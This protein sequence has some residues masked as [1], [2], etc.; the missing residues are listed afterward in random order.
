M[1]PH[2]INRPSIHLL[3]MFIHRRRLLHHTPLTPLAS[4]TTPTIPSPHP[5]F[6]QHFSL[7][8]ILLFE[9]E[10]REYNCYSGEKQEGGYYYAGYYAWGEVG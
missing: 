7:F 8:L 2:L 10:I 4:Q 1:P 3:L 9:Q 6:L 5:S